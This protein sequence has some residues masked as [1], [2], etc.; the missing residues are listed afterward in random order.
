MD[1]TDQY[2]SEY[3][4]QYIPFFEQFHSI[5]FGVLIACAVLV[6]VM[7]LIHLSIYASMSSNK[8]KYNYIG[9]YEGRM[10]KIIGFLVGL[11]IFS[12]IN[13]L[14]KGEPQKYT[15]IH[16]AVL[17]AVGAVLFIAHIYLTFMFINVYYPRVLSKKLK[18]IRYKTRRH[19]ATGNVMKLLSEEEEDKYL[20]E[21]M[22]AEENVFSV[23][24]DVWIDEK[25]GKTIIEKYEG[26]L[27][28]T[29]CENC[30]FTTMRLIKEEVIEEDNTGHERVR[31]QYQCSYCNSEEEKNGLSRKSRPTCKRS[32]EK[33]TCIGGKNTNSVRKRT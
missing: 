11:V 22:Q 10:F 28:A 12:L 33:E 30:G 8:G 13:L 31:Q 18:R 6:P 21:G 32:N 27:E 3:T 20:D 2:I 17:L 16:F 19:P 15:M 4:K 24:Y 1:S 9:K 23:D 25:T 5:I 7:Y 29:S 14:N 26:H